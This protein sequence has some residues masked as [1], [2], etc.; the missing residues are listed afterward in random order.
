MKN[1]FMRRVAILLLLFGFIICCT[2]TTA[3]NSVSI[4]IKAASFTEASGEAQIEPADG[5]FQQV[6]LAEEKG[7]LAY[8]VQVPEAGR[9]RSEVMLT[10]AD[11]N[12]ASCW[13]EDYYDNKDGRTYNIT[14]IMIIPNTMQKSS[15]AAIDGSPLNA[16]MHKMKLHIEGRET[17]VAQIKFT[18][19]KRHQVTPVIKKQNM[20]GSDWQ[21]AWSDEF[22]GQGIPDTSK[23][24]FDIG[25]W[26][27][28]NNESQY[29]M[30][31]RPENARQ[32][33][34][35]LIIESHK[36]DQ[37][38]PWT[39]AR[40][41]TRG[42]VGFIYG[43]IEFRAIVPSGDGTWAAGWTLGDAYRDELS[44]PYCGEIDILECT[45]HEIDDN[46]GAGINHASC[47]TGAFY[48]KKGNQITSTINVEN[49]SN[50]F[51]LYSIEWYP[52]KIVGYL[53]NQEYYTYDKTKDELEWP[54][55]NAQ[56]LI[57]N[58][59]MGGGMGGKID[60]GLQSQKLIIDYVRVY[61]LR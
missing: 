52:D 23:W 20:T 43:K 47:H 17:A 3:N 55:N 61:E 54:F 41:T 22:D 24:T 44:W 15:T 27:W 37:G 6:S 16:G 8:N 18:L 45:G 48:F 58:L 26:G 53:D 36:G 7:W 28:G 21:L 25:N 4:E 60:A 38:F 30:Q 42:K 39:S 1:L 33:D 57:I 9:Y 2:K 11:T 59:A 34:G 14:G 46:S 49:M 31:Y 50:D 56:N 19:L 12:G 10:T 32:E 5:G 13:I 29:Y 35:N 40:L 51:H